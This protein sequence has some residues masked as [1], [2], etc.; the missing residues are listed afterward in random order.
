MGLSLFKR[1]LFWICNKG[2]DALFRYDSCDSY[3]PLISVFPH[4]QPLCNNLVE[5]R[6]SKVKDFKTIQTLGQVEVFC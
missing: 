5:A 6:W 2:V 1:G 3:P 4:L